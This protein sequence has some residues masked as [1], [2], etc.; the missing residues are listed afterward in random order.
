MTNPPSCTSDVLSSVR[1]TRL[2]R[3][4]ACEQAIGRKHI[5]PLKCVKKTDTRSVHGKRTHVH[6]QTDEQPV[7]MLVL[8][9]VPVE[10]RIERERVNAPLELILEVRGAI[11]KC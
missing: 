6:I 7:L 9:F 8:V 1:C 10:C 11:S 5:Y 4:R 3:S 2:K